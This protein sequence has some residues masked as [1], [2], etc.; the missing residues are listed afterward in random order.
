MCRRAHGA[1]YVAWV[2]VVRG[3]FRFLAGEDR[4]ERYRSSEEA[5]RSFCKTCGSTMFFESTRWPNEI[6]IARAAISGDIDKEP[7]AH[8]FFDDRAPWSL[9]LDRLPRFG[10]GKGTEKLSDPIDEAVGNAD[11]RVRVATAV[12]LADIDRLLSAMAAVEWESKPDDMRANLEKYLR[13]H[14][15][16]WVLLATH[17]GRARGIAVVHSYPMPSDAALQLVLDDIWVDEEARKNGLGDALMKG[18]LAIAAALKAP[19]IHLSMQPRNEAA[20]HLYEKHG[21]E[22]CRDVLYQWTNEP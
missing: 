15:K 9:V 8:V 22:L 16:S 21:F 13:G 7:M 10:G 12:D 17:E 6:H 20:A 18:V 1:A 5:T 14:A 3:Q 4:L 19:M 11:A 2:G